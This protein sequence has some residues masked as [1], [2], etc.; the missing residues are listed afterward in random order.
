MESYSTWS[1]GTSGKLLLAFTSQGLEPEQG[2]VRLPL[3]WR[4]W[5]GV[6]E[7]TEGA[8]VSLAVGRRNFCSSTR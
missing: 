3:W 8:P 6:R 7:R 1:S 5:C 2:V 4:G